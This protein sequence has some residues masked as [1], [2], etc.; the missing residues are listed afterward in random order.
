VGALLSKISFNYRLPVDPLS[1]EGTGSSIEIRIPI[2]GT[3]F[4]PIMCPTDVI[5]QPFPDLTPETVRKQKKG[6]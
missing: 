3:R 2:F 6:G 4:N 5:F 1:W